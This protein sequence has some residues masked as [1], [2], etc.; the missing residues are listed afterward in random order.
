MH[1]S[2]VKF[3][4]VVRLHALLH[5]HFGNTFTIVSLELSSEVVQ[6][7]LKK[8]NYAMHEEQPNAPSR[9]PEIITKALT[10]L[11]SIELK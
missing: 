4:I 2:H 11:A 1:H 6:P 7:V 5:D 9:C 8:G 3:E 10:D